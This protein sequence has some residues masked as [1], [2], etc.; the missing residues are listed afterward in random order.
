MAVLR[1]CLR[2]LPYDLHG[3]FEVCHQHRSPRIA[4]EWML[5]VNERA[6]CW[7][8][9]QVGTLVIRAVLDRMCLI[10][11]QQLSFQTVRAK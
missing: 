9:V 7:H 6:L 10:L 1:G 2:G 11:Q 5:N 8:N 4:Q 3:N